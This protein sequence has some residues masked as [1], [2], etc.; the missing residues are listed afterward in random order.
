MTEVIEDFCLCGC[1]LKF[2]VLLPEFVFSLCALNHSDRNCYCSFVVQC[3]I[4]SIF[5]FLF[6]IKH[7]VI[8]FLNA[9]NCVIIVRN[10]RLCLRACRRLSC[11]KCQ[12][13]QYQLSYSLM[14]LC[15]FGSMSDFLAKSDEYVY[16]LADNLLDAMT[17]GEHSKSLRETEQVSSDC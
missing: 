8:L 15:V 13:S 6:R 1:W 3:V 11:S 7:T 10:L 16:K 14:C 2:F 4:C 9:W 12:Q 17:N 5:F